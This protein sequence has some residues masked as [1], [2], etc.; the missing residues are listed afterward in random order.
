MNQTSKNIDELLIRILDDTATRADL[1]VFAEWIRTEENRKYFE[2]YKKIWHT[3][4]GVQC[5]DQV[6]AVHAC[7]AG[8]KKKSGC[9][10]KSVAI[11]GDRGCDPVMCLFL[12]ETDWKHG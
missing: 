6:V 12:F 5:D 9:F 2:Q 4:T 11:C 3:T 8:K 1:R 10:A 7:F